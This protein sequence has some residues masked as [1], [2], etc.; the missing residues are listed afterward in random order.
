MNIPEADSNST[1]RSKSLSEFLRSAK[2]NLL[3]FPSLFRYYLVKLL[4]SAHYWFNFKKF[5]NYLHNSILESFLC[6]EKLFLSGFVFPRGGASSGKHWTPHPTLC[7]FLLTHHH[8]LRAQSWGG[9]LSASFSY[10]GPTCCPGACMPSSSL[11]LAYS[12][13]A[14]D[15]GRPGLT[16]LCG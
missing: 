5:K 3:I 13:G 2:T 16:R 7:S 10:L 9:L 12:D 4:L 11:L 6:K 8:R 15:Q 14:L 1:E